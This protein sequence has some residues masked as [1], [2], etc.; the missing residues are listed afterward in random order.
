MMRTTKLAPNAVTQA[1]LETRVHRV[2]YYARACVLGIPAYLIGVHLWTWVFTVSVFLG[3][4]ADFRQLYAAAYMVRTGHANE[5][6]DYDSQKYYQDKVVSPAQVALPF[7][8]PAYEALVLAP[9]SG[10][11][12]PGAYFAFLAI[13]VAT[14]GG[15]FWLLLPWMRNLMA[16]YRWLPAA[17]LLG[18][19]PFAAAL[20]QGQD[21]ILLTALLIG[22][23]VLLMD[24]H[25]FAGGGLVGLGLFKFQIV[26]PIALLF[27]LWRRL[28]FIS[29]FSV[30]L[31]V[32]TLGSVW[33]VGPEQSGLYIRSLFSMAGATAASSNL[34]HYPVPLQ[35][36]ANLHGFAFGVS[37]GKLPQLWAQTITVSL[38]VGVLVWTALRGRQ[39]TRTAHQLLLAVPCGV[40]VSYYAFIHDLSVLFLPTVVLLDFFLVYEGQHGM[41]RWIGRAAGLMFVAPLVE[42]FSPGHF[43]LA[44]IGIVSLLIGV[45]AA[46][47]NPAFACDIDAWNGTAFHGISPES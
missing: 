46:I 5:L 2:P 44:M 27:L 17:L 15:I 40:L 35:M 23:F 41:Q 47:T 19:L 7:V 28:R 22:T 13:N 30:S 34:L 18:F 31:V 37:G 6:Y 39:I 20:I 1:S 11:P 45:S 4:R 32:L 29:G 43:Y 14:L 10:L 12:Y 26:I 25:E 33:L 16:L 42:S 9:L 3:G 8:R 36:M 38:S 21:S 24:G